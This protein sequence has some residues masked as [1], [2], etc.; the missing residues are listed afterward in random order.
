[1]LGANGKGGRYGAAIQAAMQE[2]RKA[3]VTVSLEAYTADMAKVCTHRDKLFSHVKLLFSQPLPPPV[4][5]LPALCDQ[6]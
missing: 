6:L 3:G 1:M 4:H 2:A 5:L